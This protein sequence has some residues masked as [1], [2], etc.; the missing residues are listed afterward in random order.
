M[1]YLT[2]EDKDRIATGLMLYKRSLNLKQSPDNDLVEYNQIEV[3]ETD[4]L[5]ERLGLDKEYYDPGV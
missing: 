1:P 3:Q 4:D 2:K 5:A